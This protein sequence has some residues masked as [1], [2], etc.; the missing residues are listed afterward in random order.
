MLLSHVAGAVATDTSELLFNLRR[1][2][3][4][5]FNDPPLE[6]F[7]LFSLH[8]QDPDFEGE[9]PVRRLTSDSAI[10]I[11]AFSSKTVTL[12]GWSEVTIELGDTE[13][14]IVVSDYSIMYYQCAEK[15]FVQ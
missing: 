2:I 10:V 1:S 11:A 8:N 9:A 5:F 13:Q 7:V 14:C 15:F 3:R 6:L 4:R 12:L